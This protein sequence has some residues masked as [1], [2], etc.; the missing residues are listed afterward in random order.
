MNT[1]LFMFITVVSFSL[2]TSS[3][4]LP[5][6]ARRTES[7]ENITQIMWPTLYVGDLADGPVHQ[8]C[9]LIARTV[10]GPDMTHDFDMMIA[11]PPH[12]DAKTPWHCD[13]SYWLDMPDKRALSCWVAM[14]NTRLENGCMWFAAGS[15]LQPMRPHQPAAPGVHVLQCEASEEEGAPQPITA[16]WATCHGGRTLHYSR[17][18]S[19][20]GYRRGFI[21]N[22]RPAPMVQY[23]RERNYDHGK[24]GVHGI[25]GV[26]QESAK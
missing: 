3:P 18:N 26:N 22:F 24:G 14:D 11:K 19:T 4:F 9:L 23:E 7:A 20:D 6:V 10:F 13:E 21:V 1:V 25:I 8:R 5:A 17:G 2:C 12:T 16:G 15:H